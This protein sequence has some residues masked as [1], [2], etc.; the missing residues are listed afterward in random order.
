MLKHKEGYDVTLTP[1]VKENQ[2]EIKKE[3]PKQEEIKN[4]EAPVQKEPAPVVKPDEEA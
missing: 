4:E 2:Q 1:P 3:E